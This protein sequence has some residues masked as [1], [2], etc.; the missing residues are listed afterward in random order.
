MTTITDTAIFRSLQNNMNTTTSTLNDLY[1]KASSGI[2]VAEVSDAPSSVRTILS[3]RSSIVESDQYIDNSTSVEDNL[4]STEV[5]VDAVLEIMERAKE[6]AIS[7]AND[8]LS[9]SDLQSYQ[10]ELTQMQEGLLDLANTQIG[11]K[12]IFAG[13][14]DTQQPFAGDPVVYSGTGD[15]QMITVS[16]GTTVA[17]NI[18]GEELFMSPVDIFDTL[19]QLQTAIQTGDSTVIS[20]QLT[21]VEEA[22]EQIR[23]TRSEL[24]NTLSRLEDLLSMQSNYKLRLQ[25]QLSSE[26]DADLA[27]L[28]S[29]I[30]QMELSLELTMSVTGR[31][32]ALNLFDYL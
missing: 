26:E 30:T 2:A 17:S 22:A 23:S 3:C 11:G 29:D 18:T 15:H 20:A 21:G 28:L 27:T 8:A 31:V 7:T 10:D 13:Y 9:D 16:P 14:N 6:I 25:E 24:G 19:A 12:Y 4:S 5:Y 32:S 1:V